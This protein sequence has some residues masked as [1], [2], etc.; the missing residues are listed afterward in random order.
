MSGL[1]HF[2]HFVLTMLTGALW[3]PIWIICALCC[4]SSR[5]KRDDKRKDEQIELLRQLVSEKTRERK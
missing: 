3:L 4:G 5:R 1:A 2:I